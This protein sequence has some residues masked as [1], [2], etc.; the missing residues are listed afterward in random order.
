MLQGGHVHVLSGPTIPGLEK[1]A[2]LG[3]VD[4]DGH[5]CA[6]LA[7]SRSRQNPA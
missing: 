1:P 7:P 5:V 4:L 2:S 3:E 6:S